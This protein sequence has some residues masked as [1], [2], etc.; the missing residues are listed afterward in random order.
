[1]IRQTM[2]LKQCSCPTLLL[3]FDETQHP[4][5]DRY[6]CTFWAHRSNV[7]ILRGF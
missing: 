2:L 3:V 5:F 1:M 6:V 7:L 4:S